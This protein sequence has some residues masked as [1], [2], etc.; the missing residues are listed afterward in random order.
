VEP[1]TGL[2]GTWQIPA[3]P[4][5]EDYRFGG[6]WI[7]EGSQVETWTGYTPRGD[8]PP[9]LLEDPPAPPRTGTASSPRTSARGMTLSCGRLL[10]RARRTPLLDQPEWE[11][12]AATPVRRVTP[13]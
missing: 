5:I 2:S 11:T 9:E 1:G 8:L 13:H 10:P 12:G 6:S 7:R 4:Y 3:V